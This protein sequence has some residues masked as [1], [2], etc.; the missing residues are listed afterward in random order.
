MTY[1]VRALRCDNPDCGILYPAFLANQTGDSLRSYAAQQD[2]WLVDEPF[3]GE[4]I[5]LCPVCAQTFKERRKTG[6]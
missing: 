6:D 1:Y 4:L 2:R 3:E 5:D